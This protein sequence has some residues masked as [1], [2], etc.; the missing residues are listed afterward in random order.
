MFEWRKEMSF[1]VAIDGTAGTGKST[2]SKEIAKELNFTFIDTGAMYRAITLKILKNN[3]NIEDKLQLEKLL[4]ETK[5]NFEI[6]SEGNQ[7][8]ILDGKDVTGEIREDYI[9]QNASKVSVKKE[10]R[11]KLVEL[12]REMANGK[13]VIME[14]R[15]I[16]TVVFPN[17]N[18][19]IFLDGDINE[20]ASRRYKEFKAK[21][22]DVTLEQVK[23]DMIERDKR[24]K[25]KE[26]GALKVAADA[27]FVDTTYMNIQEEK[28]ELKKIIKEELD[29]Y[30]ESK[31]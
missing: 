31:K 12:Q 11:Y 9:S 15:D 25:N 1:I 7:L 13:N 20:R 30:E 2:L 28:M 8:V 10:I 26:V 18:V 29:K 6:D 24:D 5:I 17:A 21:G 23:K 19:K 14:G 22:L 3:I 27:K 4:N 16:T